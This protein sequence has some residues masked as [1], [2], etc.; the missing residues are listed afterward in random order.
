MLCIAR[1]R[2]IE[3]AGK[4]KG[5]L[6]YIPIVKKTNEDFDDRTKQMRVGIK[7]MPGKQAG[8]VDNGNSYIKSTK[9]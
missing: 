4:K 5:M 3:M 8:E 1:N 6:D 7:D 9:W 2:V